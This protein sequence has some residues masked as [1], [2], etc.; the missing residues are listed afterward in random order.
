MGSRMLMFVRQ[1]MMGAG[2]EKDLFEYCDSCRKG[3]VCA[4]VKVY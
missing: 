4:S 3:W 2:E 1:L